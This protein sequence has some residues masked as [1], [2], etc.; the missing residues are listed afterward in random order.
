MFRGCCAW[1]EELPDWQAVT[2]CVVCDLVQ[3]Q[4]VDAWVSRLILQLWSE[5]GA[6]SAVFA[7]ASLCGFCGTLAFRSQLSISSNVRQFSYMHLR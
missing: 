7:A 1:E 2:R 4:D 6:E 3:V 5:Q